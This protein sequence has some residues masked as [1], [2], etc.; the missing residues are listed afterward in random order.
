MSFPSGLAGS[1]KKRPGHRL[2]DLVQWFW[3]AEG[4]LT[5]TL[6]LKP[7]WIKWSKPARKKRGKAGGDESKEQPDNICYFNRRPTHFSHQAYTNDDSDT[8]VRTE[9]LLPTQVQLSGPEEGRL[10][11]EELAR[12][13]RLS[14]QWRKDHD[15]W[16]DDD[17]DA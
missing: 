15:L 1:S 5:T 4:S 11:V 7:G 13:T 12:L 3:N 17:E 9:W 14:D 16:D 8:V 2:G 6:K 10:S